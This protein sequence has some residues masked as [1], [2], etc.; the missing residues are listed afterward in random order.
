V[1]AAGEGELV[2]HVLGRFRPSEKP[3]IEE[4]VATANEAVSV[5]VPQGLEACMARN[6]TGKE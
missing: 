4:A 2:D 5:W 6:N 1:D 3:V